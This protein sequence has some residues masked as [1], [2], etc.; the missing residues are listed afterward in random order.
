MTC[1]DLRVLS[2][3]KIIAPLDNGN[4]FIFAGITFFFATE[5]FDPDYRRGENFPSFHFGIFLINFSMEFVW[6]FCQNFLSRQTISQL[7]SLGQIYFEI[8][9]FY[10]K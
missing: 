2:F 6:D 4:T 8:L 5:V 10:A 3:A 7:K 1:G 9:Y